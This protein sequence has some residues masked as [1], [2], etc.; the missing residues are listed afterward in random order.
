MNTQKFLIAI[1]VAVVLVL[2]VTF[3]KGN[4]VVERITT[5]F[6]AS[7]GPNMSGPYL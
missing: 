2:G 5:Q 1:G 6:G 3:P 7:A 4:T